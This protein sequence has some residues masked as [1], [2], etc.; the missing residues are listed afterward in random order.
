MRLY[1]SRALVSRCL[2]GGPSNGPAGGRRTTGST[3]RRAGSRGIIPQECPN[4]HPT[5]RGFALL[6]A[7]QREEQRQADAEEPLLPHQREGKR[8]AEATKPLLLQQREGKRQADVPKPL[9]PRQRAEKRQE[10]KRQA[11]ATQPLL[12]HHHR[13]GRRPEDAAEPLLPCQRERREEK[14][15][16][17]AQEPLLPHQREGKRLP[18]Q[19]VRQEQYPCSRPNARGPRPRQRPLSPMPATDQ[20]TKPLLKWLP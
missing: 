1:C 18:L 9:L 17:D 20:R 13:E 10:E 12:P 11:D 3:Q 15:K 19:L 8:Q 14:R 2:P 4:Q 6:L 5:T 16:A 7:Q